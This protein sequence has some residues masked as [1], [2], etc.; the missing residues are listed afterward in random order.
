MTWSVRLLVGRSV[1]ESLILLSEHLLCN[2]VVVAGERL[3]CPG[4]QAQQQHQQQQQQQDQQQ[5]Q[6]YWLPARPYERRFT[7][8][9]FTSEAFSITRYA[10]IFGTLPESSCLIF[11]LKKQV[12]RGTDGQTK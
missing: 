11:L 7:N 4:L 12:L 10:P 9:F 5:Q 8:N 2:V 6:Q 3:L 1:G